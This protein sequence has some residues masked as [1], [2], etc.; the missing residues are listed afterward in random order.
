MARVL[1]GS[2]SFTCTPTRSSAIGMSH[3]CLCLPSYSWYSVTDSGGMEGWVGLG[4][5][6]RSKAVYLPDGSN[7]PTTNRAQ[8]R[9]TA[10]IE[11]TRY[12]IQQ[13]ATGL[14]RKIKQLSVHPPHTTYLGLHC[15]N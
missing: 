9:A 13:T 2:H 7:H 4:C 8:C 6:L 3:T 11:T 1:K 12:R 14:G 15:C 5:R 10:L